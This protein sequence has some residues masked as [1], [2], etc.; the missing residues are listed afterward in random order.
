MK[1]SDR[2]KPILDVAQ[3]REQ[4]AAHVLGRVQRDLTEQRNKL[5]TLNEYR[6][7]YKQ[8]FHSQATQG[9]SAT[10]LHSFQQFIQQLD[11]AINEQLKKIFRLE[12]ACNSSRKNWQH[13]RQHTQV[14]DSVMTRFENLEKVQQGRR[15][16]RML[17]EMIAARFWR[18]KN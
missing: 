9:I 10:Q 5:Y 3:R 11:L 15:E 16:Q 2:M 7:E 12:E 6:E 13:E 1:R 8:R 14:L 4:Q 17:D 18:S